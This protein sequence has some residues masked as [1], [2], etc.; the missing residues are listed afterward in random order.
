[1]QYLVFAKL[2]TSSLRVKILKHLRT[3]MTGIAIA[4]IYLNRQLYKTYRGVTLLN[5]YLIN[6]IS[7]IPD[8]VFI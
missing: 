3:G 5:V 2:A 4:K 7:E 8:F 1:M 6:S